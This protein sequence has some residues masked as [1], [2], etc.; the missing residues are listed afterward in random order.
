MKLLF[1]LLFLLATTLHA[2]TYYVDKG[3]PL[4]SD[5]NPGTNLLPWMTCG[6]AAATMVAGDNVSIFGG[7]YDERCTPA[8]SGLAGMPITFTGLASIRGFTVQDKK[9]I[10]IQGFEIT[11]LGMASDA[12][13][14]ILATGSTGVTILNNIIHDTAAFSIRCNPNNA[15][16]KCNGLVVRGNTMTRIGPA[17]PGGAGR[18]PI[19]EL[20]G[21]N[22]LIEGNDLSRGEDFLRVYG[23]RNVFR[24]NT[25]H[26]SIEAETPNGTQHIDGFQSFCNGTPAQAA[27]YLLVEGNTM[28]DNPGLNTHFG[29]INGT[30]TCGG[31]STVIVRYN[32]IQNA[33]SFSYVADTNGGLADHQK[34]YSNTTVNSSRNSHVAADLSGA[35]QGA[36]LNNIFVDAIVPTAPAQVYLLDG[37]G[38]SRSGS[39]LAYMSSFPSQLWA[40]PINS[41]SGVIL[42]HDPLL[43]ADL[44]LL[45]GSPAIGT[46]G[47]LTAVA[48]SD[49]GGTTLFL[50]DASF[51]QPGWAGVRPDCI[52][53]GIASNT[54]CIVSIDYSAN[55]AVLSAPVIRKP[56]DPIWLF[57]NSSGVQVLFGAPDRGAY[58]FGDT[59]PVPPHVPDP[60]IASFT[61]SPTSGIVPLT[62][63]FADT[64]THGPTSW[65]WDFG[66]GTGSTLQ[67]PTKAYSVA[68]AYTVRLTVT[69]ADGSTSTT[70][71]V[72]ALAAPP[73]VPVDTPPVPGGNGLISIESVNSQRLIL[74][75]APA[76]DDKSG[77]LYQVLQNGVVVKP[78]TSGLSNYTASGLKAGSTYAFKV[79]V[80]DSA[81]QTAIYTTA[82]VPTEYGW[83]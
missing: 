8:R 83:H 34:F 29:L 26:D 47:P 33:G 50:Q 70:R 54:A 75:W 2:E 7:P 14:S 74:S 19:I 20:W 62:V 6:K 63:T 15:A 55:S 51:F 38:S 39:N 66:N 40:S 64:S 57:S 41:E 60:P 56:G 18:F 68:G 45:P 46:G 82:K 13:A 30:D 58:P 36:V 44:K 79:I 73:P 78:Y 72:T 32:V 31:S 80:K 48:A 43:G 27:S 53:V 12:N 4:A 42:N 5:T 11:S 52:A 10:T 35:T 49:S 25:L 17:W 76:T 59:V 24:N 28:R 37:S 69:N 61:A 21:D 81:G 67:N 16:A 9:Y 3:N 65:A 71:A 23:N 77:L 22:S 1:T